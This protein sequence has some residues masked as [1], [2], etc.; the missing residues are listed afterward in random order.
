MVGFYKCFMVLV[1]SGEVVDF[2]DFSGS[3]FQ[4]LFFL[5]WQTWVAS[6]VGFL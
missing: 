6:L 3:R 1:V 2:N 5:Q 4:M